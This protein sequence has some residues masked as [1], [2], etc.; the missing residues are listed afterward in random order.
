MYHCKK[1]ARNLF[2]GMLLKWNIWDQDCWKLDTSKYIGRCTYGRNSLAKEKIIFQLVAQATCIIFALMFC[3]EL[4]ESQVEGIEVSYHACGV[5]A[6]LM[7]DGPEAWTIE[8]P[9]RWAVRKRMLSALRRW[10]TAARRHINYRYSFQTFIFGQSI[11][12]DNSS[13]GIL[14]AILLFWLL[15]LYLCEN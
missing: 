1:D 10:S 4:L 12:N 14:I 15:F 3:S 9:E 2:R 7:S 5:L 6:H 13:V 11:M 8:Q